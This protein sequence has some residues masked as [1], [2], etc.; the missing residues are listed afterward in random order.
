VTTTDPGVSVPND[1]SFEQLM[2]IISDAKAGSLDPLSTAIAI[3]ASLGN[4]VS[5]SGD[6]LR[7]A[8]TASSLAMNGPLSDVAN[9]IQSILKTGNQ[10]KFTN[11]QTSEF[12]LR[13][14]TMRFLAEVAFTVSQDGTLPALTNIT[15][16]AVH[17][18][19]WIDIQAMAVK[20]TSDQTLLHVVTAA[21]SRDIALG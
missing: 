4:T 13:D 9:R 10:V 15:G 6:L 16:F 20:K 1:L 17:K 2:K 14:T 7:Q 19:F 5:V 3:F 21:G 12:T 11:T 8:L 18:V